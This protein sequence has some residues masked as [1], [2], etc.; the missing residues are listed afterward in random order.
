MVQ[1]FQPFFKLLF[2]THTYTQSKID[3]QTDRG[4]ERQRDS[5]RHRE[6]QTEREVTVLDRKCTLTRPFIVMVARFVD[7]LPRTHPFP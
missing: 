7:N 1:Q 3:R 6:R 2:Y 5:K 4:R